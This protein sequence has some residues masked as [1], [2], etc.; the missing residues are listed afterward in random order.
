MKLNVDFKNTVISFLVVIVIMLIA[1]T[2]KLYIFQDEPKDIPDKSETEVK[3]DLL[4]KDI[5]LRFSVTDSLLKD[6][7]RRIV[8]SKIITIIQKEAKD[9]K[10]DVTNLPI[11]GKIKYL[12]SWIDSLK[13][14][15]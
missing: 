14:H 1:I 10:D 5:S 4:Q 3:Y 2:L 8:P 15:S 12:S 7:H 11:S 6:Y 13:R 9:E